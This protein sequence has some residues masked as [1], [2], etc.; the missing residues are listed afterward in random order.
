MIPKKRKSAHIEGVRQPAMMHV[1]APNS[2]PRHEM[3]LVV[4]IALG[5]DYIR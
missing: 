4:I 1:A 5:I 2:V 3:G